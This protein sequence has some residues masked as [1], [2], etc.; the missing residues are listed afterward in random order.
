MSLVDLGK[1]LLEAARKGHDDE[2]RN[3][4]ANG[5]PFTTDW[6]GT[7]PLHLAA[8][9]GHYST[10]DVLI[11]AG[12]SRDAR[13][14]VDRTPLHMAAA[15]GHSIIVELLVRSGADINA[16]DML[17]MTA[18]HW[19]AQHGHQGVAE[20]LIKHGADVHSLS[21]FDKTPFDIAVDIQNTEL[22]LL[23]QE[24][25]QNQV[26]MNQVSVNVDNSSS[27]PQFIIQG[28]PS[29][30]GGVVNLA[31][32]LN[33]ANAGESEEA[34]AASALDPSVQHTVVNEGG[35]R[36]IT[37]VTDQHGNLQT[38]TGAMTQPFFVTMQHGQQMLVPAN[39]VTE[40]VVSEEPPTRKRKLD[41]TPEL[42]ETELLQRQLQ[43]ANRKAQEYRTQL[44]RKE[45]EAEEYRIKLEAMSQASSSANPEANHANHANGEQ[46][47]V[48]GEEEVVG[49]IMTDE[50]EGQEVTLVT[51]SE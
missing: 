13:T 1:R 43:E 31:E 2:V 30:Q 10:A 37:I 26:N 39:T 45:Q 24:G 47:E 9:H 15:E 12:V 4:M 29:L 50:G 41:P 19:A 46:D 27:Q 3:L 33:K 36:V 21:K 8:Q 34:M 44:L 17:K 18:L 22:M 48:Q 49:I 7:S 14:K 40:E 38:A 28:L 16:K 25:M 23:L 32:L 5:A 6:L 35:Q 11:R 51:G 42:Q 20:T